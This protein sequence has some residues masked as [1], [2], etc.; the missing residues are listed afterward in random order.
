M[1]AWAQA[2]D[3]AWAQ[4]QVQAQAQAPQGLA[5]DSHWQRW[6]SVPRRPSSRKVAA[7][8]QVRHAWNQPCSR[9]TWFLP[10]VPQSPPRRSR[11]HGLGP[12]AAAKCR[13]HR[14]SRC[15]P[16]PLTVTQAAYKCGRIKR[17]DPGFIT[18][19][20]SRMQWHACAARQLPTRHTPHFTAL[21][22]GQAVAPTPL[23]S[24]H[25]PTP[26]FTRPLHSHPPDSLLQ[27]A[28][29]GCVLGREASHEVAKRLCMLPE[30]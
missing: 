27:H 22:G 30:P 8:G 25:R 4:A 6:R 10:Q 3:Q 15:Q 14:Q 16:R 18:H 21:T 29:A 23:A 12:P 17:R 7:A 11:R 9:I 13:H 19:T 1:Q 20:V 26:S 28:A 5:A 24:P 2:Q